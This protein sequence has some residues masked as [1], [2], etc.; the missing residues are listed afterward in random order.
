MSYGT[1]VLTAGFLKNEGLRTTKGSATYVTITQYITLM[2]LYVDNFYSPLNGVLVHRRA[3]PSIHR[4]PFI[5]LCGE[6][7]DN[8]GSSPRT[9]QNVPKVQTRSARSGVEHTNHEATA[10]IYYIKGINVLSDEQHG[11]PPFYSI[12]SQRVHRVN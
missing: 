10:P 8:L 9:Q 1:K 3:T 11:N 12:S 6:R 2:S 7:H 5:H 4:Y